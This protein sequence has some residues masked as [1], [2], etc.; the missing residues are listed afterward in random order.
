[1]IK[2][3]RW[4]A[5]GCTHVPLIDLDAREWILE[6]IRGWRPNWV[7]Y[8]G[9]G[10]ES[11]SASRW[12]HEYEWTLSGEFRKHDQFLRDIRL[13]APNSQRVFCWG[14]HDANL[15][16]INRIDRQLRD[17][18]DPRDHE[19]EL[20]AWRQVPYVYCRRR[21][22]FRLGQVAFSHG[23]EHGANSDE[24]QA[25]LLG[26]PFGL[27]VSGHT[28]RPVAVTQACKTR[29]IPLPYWY[30]NVGCLRDLKPAYVER[31]RT[32]GWGHA[33]VVGECL[34][35]KSPRLSRQWSAETRIFKMYDDWGRP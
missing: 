6:Q 15:L 11:A 35:T 18:C 5:F 10:H 31:K 4:I 28:H 34:P 1:M 8:L 14:N 23:Y 22:V 33:C 24:A 20:K 7:I 9:D 26:D 12:P 21:G 2:P 30:A 17:L 25:I 16:A 19:K 13:E 29:T 3:V 27:F 32:H